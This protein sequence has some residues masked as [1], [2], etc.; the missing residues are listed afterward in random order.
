MAEL[1]GFERE[2]FK[3]EEFV[4]ELVQECVAGS[5]LQQRKTKLENLNLN[6]SNSLKRHVF[7][8]YLQFIDTAREI[9]REYWSLECQKRNKNI[10]N[11]PLNPIIKF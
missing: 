6:V 11:T 3:P 2:N 5:E 10:Q 9:S 1:H 8:N 7:T 4:K